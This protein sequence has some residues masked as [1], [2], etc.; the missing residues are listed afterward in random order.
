MV[1]QVV[2]G[3]SQSVTGIIFVQQLTDQIFGVLHKVVTRV[4]H[5][6]REFKVARHYLIIDFLHIVSVDLNEWIFPC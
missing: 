6:V 5:E 2:V 4:L 3:A 1:F